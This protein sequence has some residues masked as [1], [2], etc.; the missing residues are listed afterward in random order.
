MLKAAARV[1]LLTMLTITSAFAQA[2]VH[3]DRPVYAQVLPDSVLSFPADLGAHPDFR[4][5]WWYVTGWLHTPDGPRGFQIT[6]FRSR[7]D[8]E[9]D[10]PS[11]FSPRQI[12]FAH[13]ALSDPH[14]G[15]L[16]QDQ[17]IARQGFGLANATTGDTNVELSNWHL[18]RSPDGTYSA[19]A[20]TGKFS[21]DLRLQPTQA[22][23][24]QGD[25]GYS[26]KGAAVN[27]ASYYYSVPHLAVSGRLEQD[28]HT[29]D[30]SG[31]AWLDHEWSSNFL[32]ARSSGWDWTGLNLDDGSALTAFQVRDASGKS[33]WAG[34]SFRSA[35]GSTVALGPDDIR[36]AT[37]RSWQSPR[38][39]TRYPVVQTL[40]VKLPTGSRQFTL[41]PLFDDQE[42]DSRAT[43]GPVYWEGAVKTEGGNGY[44]E[45][46]G[47][48]AAVKP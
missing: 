48:S 14:V 27:A 7:P 8:V 32:A 12:L 21:L 41:T 23:L 46:V 31:E 24:I 42:L 40:T 4:T 43:G 47:Y 13:V 22:A 6:F 5:E 19:N 28:G 9:Q 20:D 18:V 30:V 44:L 16:V 26:K 10:N 35:S 3:S 25:H 36:F 45:L 11:A 15:K 33:E 34:G 1:V 29:V 2:P 38:T 17:R 39:G 37:R